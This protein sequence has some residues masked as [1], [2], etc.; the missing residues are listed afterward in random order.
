[1]KII[2]TP[3]TITSEEAALLNAVIRAW[4]D[5]YVLNR[6]QKAQV[7]TLFDKVFETKPSSI[8]GGYYI[9]YVDAIVFRTHFESSKAQ[10]FAILQEEGDTEWK[11]YHIDFEGSHCFT[12]HPLPYMP[13]SLRIALFRHGL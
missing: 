4:E 6:C 11:A 3:I 5:P 13:F 8:E 1:M 10:F 2:E 7:K 9:P 12:Y